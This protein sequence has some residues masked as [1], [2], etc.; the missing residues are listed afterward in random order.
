MR[1]LRI[2][3]SKEEV[4]TRTGA[5]GALSFV[6]EESDEIEG[7]G[8][9]NVCNVTEANAAQMERPE[10]QAKWP[11]PTEVFN[12]DSEEE[13]QGYGVVKVYN[14]TD[15]NAAQMERPEPQAKWPKPTEM[16]EDD[17]E[18]E[19]EARE[20]PKLSVLEKKP[21]AK[22]AP[23][24][25]FIDDLKERSNA[26]ELLEEIMDQKVSIRLKDIDELRLRKQRKRM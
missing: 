23:K 19:A 13:V 10:P 12:E 24:R 26:E 5:K 22:P 7:Y 11:K 6:N 20:E 21:R 17:V 3:L 1:T 9:V 16:L 2:D 14:V 8:V 4:S 18:M 25:R 15:A